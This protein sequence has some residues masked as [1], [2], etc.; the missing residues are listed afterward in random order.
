MIVQGKELKNW[1]EEKAIF[2][3]AKTMREINEKIS[4]F[5]ARNETGKVKQFFQPPV[6]TK[7]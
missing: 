5:F 2:I 6:V 4:P 1:I 7:L 3:F